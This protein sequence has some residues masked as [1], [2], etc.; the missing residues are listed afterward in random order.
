M[1]ELESQQTSEDM[2]DFIIG[3]K[4]SFTPPGEKEIKG[5]VIKKNKKTITGV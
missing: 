4:I 3:D 1:K 5:I 2:N